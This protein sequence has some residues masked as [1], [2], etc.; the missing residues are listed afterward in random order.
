MSELSFSKDPS[1][2]QIQRAMIAWVSL[3]PSIRDF[4]IHIPNQGRRTNFYGALL[5]KLGMKGGIPDLFIAIPRQG[6]AGCFIEVKR[7][8]G[9]PSP[10]QKD[11]LIKLANNSYFT[12][13]VYS[14]DQGIEVI[15]EYCFGKNLEKLKSLSYTSSI[16]A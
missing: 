2:E 15:D 6:Y 5:K 10:N 16:K 12:C 7:K 14:I 9:I 13:I 3:Q 11:Y 8:K 4:V 1:E